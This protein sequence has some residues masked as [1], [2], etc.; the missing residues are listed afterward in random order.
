MAPQAIEIAQN[1]LGNG[2]PPGSRDRIGETRGS[3]KPNARP[4]DKAATKANVG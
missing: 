2:K 1:G 3:L 4:T